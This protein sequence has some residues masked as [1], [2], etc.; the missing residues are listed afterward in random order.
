MK[1]KFA[2]FRL[3]AEMEN[4][5]V[6]AVNFSEE[7]LQKLNKV[8]GNI[9]PGKVTLHDTPFCTCNDLDPKK[10]EALDEELAC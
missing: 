1:D 8:L 5:D 6:H 2:K 4:G 7:Q 9:F 3:V 10:V